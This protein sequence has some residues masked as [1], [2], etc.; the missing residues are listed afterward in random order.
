MSPQSAEKLRF[1]F[2]PSVLLAF[3]LNSALPLW[4]KS[5]QVD[6]PW[7]I[8]GRNNQLLKI[9]F[10]DQSFDNTSR[11]KIDLG[12]GVQV[13][14]HQYNQKEKE[15]FLK[16]KSVAKETNLGPRPIIIKIPSK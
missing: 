15:L 2:I 4:G 8:S 14:S 1:I 16:I 9:R 13:A 5:L 7:L 10:Y 6:S 11:I 12:V 3:L